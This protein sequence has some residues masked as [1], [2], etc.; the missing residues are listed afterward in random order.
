MNTIVVIPALNESKRIAKVIG[1]TLSMVDEVIV[2]DDH[3]QDPTFEVAKKKGAKSIRLATNMG[4]GFATRLGCDIACSNEADV[5]ITLDADGKHDPA[6]IPKLVKTLQKGKYDIVFGSRP[7]D[8]N[9]PW[10]KRIGN[11]GLSWIA[12]FLFGVNISDSQT[13]FHAFTKE[14]YPKIRWESER[15]GMVSEFIMNVGK[16]R[17]SYKEVPIKTIYTDKQTGMSKIDAL[18]SAFSMLSW[19]LRKW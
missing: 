4:A 10:I 17:L 14:S 6:E 8:K 16:H 12:S 1:Q 19:R 3:S 7:R 15:Y 11:S 5:I 18:K 2:V 9:M 13:G